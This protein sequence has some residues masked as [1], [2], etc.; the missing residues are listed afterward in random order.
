MTNEN[1]KPKLIIIDCDGVLYDPSE[2]DV[3]AMVY[4]FNDVCEDFDLKD[5]KF[6]YVEDCTRDKPIK[7]FCNYIEFVAQ[8]IGLTTEDFILK[9]V[10]HVDYSHLKP[11]ES[12]IL[13]Q[14]KELSRKYKICICSNNHISHLNKVLQAKFNI[15]ANHLPFEVFDIGDTL[16]D[17][18]YCSKQSPSFVAKLEKYFGVKASDFL[19]IDDSPKI[20]DKI[21][22]FGGQAILVTK[23]NRLKDVLEKL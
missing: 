1:I 18:V 3:N 10:E 15:C 2:L 17:G 23:D 4:A 12:G 6:N 8:K 20:L 11:D 14:L 21:K 16:F 5:E 13:A 7:S 22:E 9:M 19:W